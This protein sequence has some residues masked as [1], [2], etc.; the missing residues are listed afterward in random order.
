MVHIASVVGA[1]QQANRKKQSPSYPEIQK[2]L[3]F[4]FCRRWAAK[5]AM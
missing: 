2:E 3:R 5:L 1:I 4:G